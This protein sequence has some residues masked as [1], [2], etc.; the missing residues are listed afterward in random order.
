MK[1]KISILKAEILAFLPE[2]HDQLEQF[3]IQF[4]GK[5]GKIQDLFAD[6]KDVAP[7]LRKIGRA[8]V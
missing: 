6:F 7:E 8:H 2:N 1:E 4:L 5:K 3:R